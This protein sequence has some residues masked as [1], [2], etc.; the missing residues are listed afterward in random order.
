MEFSSH[1]PDNLSELLVKIVQFTERRRDV[2]YENI[3]NTRTPGFTPRDMPVPEFVPI[4]NGAIA[5][6]LQHQRLLFCDSENIRFGKNTVMDI[7]PVPD[8]PAQALLQDNRDEYIELQ[9][10]KLLENSL[11][12]KVA[13]E[14]LRLKGGLSSTLAELSTNMNE[15]PEGVPFDDSA[16]PGNDTA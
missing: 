2:L 1:I 6:H 9:I 4:L 15:I 16:N 11:N 12:R 8:P 5:E 13:K 10:G 3:H 14:L 7:T